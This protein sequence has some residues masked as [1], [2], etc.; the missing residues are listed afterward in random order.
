MKRKDFIKVLASTTMIGTGLKSL[1]KTV[2]NWQDTAKM[3]VL[4]VGHGNPMNAISENSI[5]R[6]WRE[7]G[8]GLQ[9]KA[10]LCISAHWQTKGT[11][12]TMVDK[13][14][15]IHDFGGFP[16]ALF[17][18]DYPA[19]G[20]PDVGKAVIDSVN[21]AT[22]EEDHEWGLDHGTWSVLIKMFPSADIPVLQ[23]SLD[24]RQ[25]PKY[26]YE[27]AKQLA[28]LR[29]KGVLIVGSGNI[30]HNLRMARWQSNEPYDWAVDFDQ[31]VKELIDTRSHE[32]LINYDSLGT[33]AKLSIPTN[34]HYIPMLSALALQNDEDETS[35]FNDHIDMGSMAMRSFV[36]G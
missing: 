16:Q 3:P 12:V 7:M 8:K 18:V 27:L 17:D 4:F 5:T 34:E 33:P 23:M 35:Y 9:P 2:E 36:V 13:P 28:F 31:Q 29:N 15:T 25:G 11:K 26:H 20:A 10:I 24:Y 1:G 19:P 30:I 22:V 32:P 6:G 21:Y 14:A